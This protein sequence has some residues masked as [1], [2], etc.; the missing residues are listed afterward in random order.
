MCITQETWLE[1]HWEICLGPTLSSYGYDQPKG[2]DTRPGDTNTPTPGSMI[3]KHSVTNLSDDIYLVYSKRRHGRGGYI[4][5]S[6][7]RA[8]WFDMHHR[9]PR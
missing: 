7:M 6:T 9:K 8:E 3:C 1:R 2:I 4:G 5:S